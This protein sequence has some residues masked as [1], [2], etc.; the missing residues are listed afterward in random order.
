MKKLTFIMSQRTGQNRTAGFS[1]TWYFDGD[2]ASAKLSADSVAKKR[3]ALMTSAASINALRIQ[4]IG[5][6]ARIFQ[7]VYPGN[8]TTGQDIPQ[9]ALNLRVDGQGFLNSKTFQIRGLPDV[10]VATGDYTPVAG[11]AGLLNQYAGSLASWSFRFRGER[12]SN[13][14]VAILSVSSL[15]VFVLA[16]DLVFNI[17]DYVTLLRTNNTTGLNVSGRYYVSAKTTAQSGTLAAW[18]GGTVTNKGKM[19]KFDYDYPIVAANSLVV[20]QVTTRKVGRPFDL[21]RG[22]ATKR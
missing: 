5:S 2:L 4:D 13:P 19:R 12:L 15:G 7:F 20:G 16:A 6:R 17:G 14:Q 10:N 3:A 18:D 22:R 1:E 11:Y 8:I 21:Y 9:M